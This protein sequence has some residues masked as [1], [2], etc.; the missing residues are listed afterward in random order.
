MNLIAMLSALVVQDP[1]VVSRQTFWSFL[2]SGGPVM[3][4]I[5]ICSVVATAFAMERY[6]R[7]RRGLVCPK[8]TEDALQLVRDGEWMEAR[9]RASGMRAPSGRI[10]VAGLRRQGFDLNEVEKAME[11]QGQ[12]ELERLRAPIRPILL[13]GNITPLMGLLGTVIGISEAFHR[14]VRTGM[15]KPEHLAGGIEQALTTTI[16]GLVVAI[17]ALLIAAHLNSRV[18]QLL[19]FTDEKL[20]PVVELVARQSGEES[21]AA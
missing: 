4:P 1:E 13:I 14:V 11:D 17:P 5:A 12:K 3:I 6:L 10:L 2:E 21:D 16:V 19:L 8:K 7:L 15:G 20:A 9:A 18:R